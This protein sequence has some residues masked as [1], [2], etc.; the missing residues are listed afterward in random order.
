MKLTKEE[1]LEALHYLLGG[2]CSYCWKTHGKETDVECQESKQMLEQLINEHFELKEAH[3]KLC[4]S[5][6]P[7]SDKHDEIIRFITNPSLKFEELKKCMWVWDSKWDSYIQIRYITPRGEIGVYMPDYIYGDMQ[8]ID[9]VYFKF[10]ENRYFRK[11]V[12]E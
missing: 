6:F 8:G 7:F 9:V 4:N 3:Q 5:F 2:Q 11:Q 1:C 12:E 10:E